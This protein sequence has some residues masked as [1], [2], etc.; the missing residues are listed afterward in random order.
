MS[1]PAELMPD[2]RVSIP[3]RERLDRLERRC[4]ALWSEEPG[5]AV[6]REAA[7]AQLSQLDH[8][9]VAL[10][11]RS[12]GGHDEHALI[13]ETERCERDLEDVTASWTDDR[14]A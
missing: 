3:I 13:I 1:T 4:A 14:A 12:L 11:L 9:I 6:D 5:F 2:T 7:Y 10:I 8:R